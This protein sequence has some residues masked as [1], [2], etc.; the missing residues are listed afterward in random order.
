MKNIATVLLFLLVIFSCD[1]KEVKKDTEVV[2]EVPVLDKEF[3]PVDDELIEEVSEL[4]FTVQIAA[5]RN[6][7]KK[8]AN[9]NNV[10]IYQENSLSKYSLGTF[11]T[12]E[13]ART[14][15]LNIINEYKGAFVQALK[16]NV[17]IP[18]TEAL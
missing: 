13:E 5:L 4:I 12:Y 6:R 1:K 17:P 14:Y 3:V 11:E 9:I 16:N 10:R 18:I 15:R 2:L 7:N 8:M